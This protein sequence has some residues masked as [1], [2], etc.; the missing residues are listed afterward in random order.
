MHCQYVLI[1]AIT[2][3]GIFVVVVVFVIVAATHATVCA[4]RRQRADVSSTPSRR[5]RKAGV[6]LLH[7]GQLVAVAVAA[8][9]NAAIAIRRRL[10]RDAGS[11]GGDAIGVDNGGGR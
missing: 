10:F 8:V 1:F 11:V 3:F 2:T 6:K 4:S 7:L 5:T 9:G